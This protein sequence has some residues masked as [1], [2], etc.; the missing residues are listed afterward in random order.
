MIVATL[1]VTTTMPNGH[2]FSEKEDR[3][4]QHIIDSEVQRGVP[5]SEAKKIA[6]AHIN[7]MHG[8]TAHAGLKSGGGPHSTHLTHRPRPRV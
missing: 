3:Q 8:H 2:R 5:A 6:Y 1:I 4:A 7:K